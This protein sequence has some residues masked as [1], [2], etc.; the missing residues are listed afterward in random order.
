MDVCITGIKIITVQTMLDAMNIHR[1]SPRP[2]PQT[3]CDWGVLHV[4]SQGDNLVTQIMRQYGGVDRLVPMAHDP[5]NNG[6][7]YPDQLYSQLEGRKP[8]HTLRLQA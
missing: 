5:A 3:S 4:V 7:N 8:G 6:S 2:Q 1:T